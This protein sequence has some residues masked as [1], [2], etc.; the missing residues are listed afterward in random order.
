ME[1]HVFEALRPQREDYGAE[2]VSEEMW[3]VLE[4]CWDFSPHAR[5]NIG[6][7]LTSPAF[8]ALSAEELIDF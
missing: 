2:V 7:I 1:F 8:F 6:Q 4:R 5:P 3:D